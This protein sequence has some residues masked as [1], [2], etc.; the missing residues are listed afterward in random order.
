[1]S[2]AVMRV[3]KTGNYTIM[4][5]HHFKEKGMS[6]KAKGLLSMMLSLPDDWDYSIMG[7]VQLSKDGKDSV[8]G[9]L[10]ELEDFGY[11]TRTRKQDE[12][13][14]FAGYDYDIYEFPNADLRTPCAEKPCAEKPNTGKPNAEKPTQLNTNQINDEGINVRNDQD[15]TDIHDKRPSPSSEDLSTIDCGKPNAF[16]KKLIEAGYI[17]ED[18]LFITMYN[19]LFEELNHDHKFEIVRACLWYFVKRLRNGKAY[20]E[21]GNEIEN[22]HAYLK[23][24]LINGISMMERMNEQPDPYSE[25]GA[26]RFLESI[27][28]KVS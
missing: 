5:N 7:L 23:T 3:H 26:K 22:K 28:V 25:E 8:M 4:S 11:L 6:L 19:Q 18:D 17:E 2:M 27:G 13:G 20:D 16:T 15:K 21:G 1:M 12:K 10:K 24:S 9:A 14:K